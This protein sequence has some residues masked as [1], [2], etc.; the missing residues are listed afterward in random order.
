INIMIKAFFIVL[1]IF[2]VCILFIP[3]SYINKLLNANYFDKSAQD[4]SQKAENY[5]KRMLEELQKY[6]DASNFSIEIGATM[7]F[8]NGRD[9]GIMNIANPESNIYNMIVEVYL[10]E[11]EEL[12]YESS[13]L[14]P[15]DYIEN[16]NLRVFLEKGVYDATAVVKAVASNNNDI[17]GEVAFDVIIHILA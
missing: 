11:T 6:A 15:G 1:I 8:Q 9:S 3:K 7:I 13:V 12:I 10:N 17:I 14:E 16:D 4:I 2:I 5:E